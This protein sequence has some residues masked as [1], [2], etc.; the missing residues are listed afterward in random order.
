MVNALTNDSTSQ[1]AEKNTKIDTTIF[2][3]VALYGFTN[4]ECLLTQNT[5]I[6]AKRSATSTVEQNM[7]Q[8]TIFRWFIFV[9]DYFILNSVLRFNSLPSSSS[10][11]VARGFVLP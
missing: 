11:L 7:T 10:S 5:I 4:L 9:E 2:K 8:L 1:K 3:A 6:P